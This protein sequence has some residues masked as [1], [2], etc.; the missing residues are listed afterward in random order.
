MTHKNITNHTCTYRNLLDKLM[1]FTQI[2]FLFFIG[3]VGMR[4]PKRLG[5]ILQKG[6]KLFNVLISYFGIQG[7]GASDCERN[8]LGFLLFR[9][10]VGI[11]DV[12]VN[13]YKSVERKGWASV[14]VSLAN[15]LEGLDD[16]VTHNR[17]KH[18]SRTHNQFQLYHPIILHRSEESP[19]A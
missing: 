12:Y 19:L 7:I 8:N 9:I 6:T 4:F 15:A 2:L 17:N 11:Q 13:L 14:S 1:N 10:F 3:K 5:L 16:P 18:Y